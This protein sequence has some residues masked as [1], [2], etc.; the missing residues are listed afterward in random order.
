MK[1]LL[2]L[3]S[4]G[5]VRLVPRRG[6]VVEPFSRQDIHDLFW[7]QGVLAGELAARA[8]RTIEP[9]QLAHLEQLVEQYAVAQENNDRDA[10]GR[11]GH[12]FHREIN[13]ASGATR[14][15]AL[16]GSVVRHLPNRFYAE[17]EGQV[18]ATTDDHPMILEALRERNPKK[19]R[20]RM[21]QHIVRG[22]DNLI[23]ML[24]HRGLW[25]DTTSS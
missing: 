23:E 22:G 11:L 10:V 19:A 21:E 5:L 1:E 8:A 15:A 20:R 9:A 25:T 3:R 2:S 14:L 13:I 16:L 7:T 17:I 6:F 18:E 24:E 4:E 12:Y